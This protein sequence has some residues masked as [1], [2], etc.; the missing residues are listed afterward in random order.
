MVIFSYSVK[1]DYNKLNYLFYVYVY[2]YFL[3]E[4]G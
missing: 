4:L 1:S 3:G 2:V